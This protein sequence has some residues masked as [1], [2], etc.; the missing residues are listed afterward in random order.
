MTILYEIIV[1]YKH[2]EMFSIKKTVLIISVSKNFIFF[3]LTVLFISLVFLR[4][5]WL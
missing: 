1:T 3:V 5:Y 2:N 4:F